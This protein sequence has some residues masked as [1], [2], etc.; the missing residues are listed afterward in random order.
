[1]D[2]DSSSRSVRTALLPAAGP[3]ASCDTGRAAAGRAGSFNS[4][5]NVYVTVLRY[6]SESGSGTAGP[7]RGGGQPGPAVPL[8]SVPVAPGRPARRAAAARALTSWHIDIMAG[9][10]RVKVTSYRDIHSSLSAGHALA[11]PAGHRVQ[12]EPD[13]VTA[14]DSDSAWQ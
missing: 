8:G 13:S 11:R 1:M 10:I 3:P 9:G 5:T 12:A 14:R 6:I 4:G 7:N 2:A